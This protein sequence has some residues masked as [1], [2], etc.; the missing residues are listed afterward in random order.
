MSKQK[1]KKGF[2]HWVGKAHLVLGLASGL[3]VLLLGVTGCIFVFSQEITNTL[4]EDAIYV[5]E[6]NA[7]PVPVSQL[8]KQAQAQIGDSLTITNVTVYSDPKQSVVFHCYKFGGENLFYYDNIDQY[9]SVYTNQYTGKVLRVYDEELDFFV[10]IKALHWSLLMKDSV[11]QVITGWATFIFVIMLIT[12]IILWWPK[13]KAARKQRLWFQWKDTTKWRRKNYDLHNIFGFYIATVA[14]IIAF[15]GMVWAFQWFYATVYVVASGSTT[16][17]EQLASKSVIAKTDKDAAYDLAFTN[18]MKRHAGA[19]SFSSGKPADSLAP[20]DIY[21]GQNAGTYWQSHQVQCDQYTG[22]FIA[23]RLHSDKN[24]GEQLLTAN[25]DI[26]VGAILGIP[27]K[28]LA[29]IASFISA[30]L[31]VTGF[32][33]WRGRVKKSPKNVPSKRVGN[34]AT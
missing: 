17:P 7:T 24:F 33:I 12:G 19:D 29:F 28:I 1:K 34:L 31:P 30:M 2:K 9:V 5:K 20:I 4:R 21:V 16:P 11:G 32:L 25:Y 23:E 14:L 27:G 22:K 26:H 18:A 3:I 8:W 6:V 13:N 10:F 15:T